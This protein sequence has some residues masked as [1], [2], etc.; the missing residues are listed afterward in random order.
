MSDKRTLI[1]HFTDGS[2][3]SVA[4]PKQTDD[5]HQLASRIQ[6]ALDANQLAIE[7]DDEFFVIPM[8]NIKYLQINPVPEKLPDSVIRGGSLNIGY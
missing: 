8:N 5:I 2:K 1:I 4:F 3:L 7:M 6:K